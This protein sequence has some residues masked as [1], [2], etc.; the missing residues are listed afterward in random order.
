[1]QSNQPLQRMQQL[2]QL[3]AQTE[4]AVHNQIV[5]FVASFGNS[6]QT[7]EPIRQKLC[8]TLCKRTNHLWILIYNHSIQI[9][10]YKYIL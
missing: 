7:S 4:S 1:M 3:N 8:E 5:K 10:D 6:E 2:T 9:N